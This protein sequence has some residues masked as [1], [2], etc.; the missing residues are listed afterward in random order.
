MSKQCFFPTPSITSN[1]WMSFC[2]AALLQ[3]PSHTNSGN[4]CVNM[5]INFLCSFLLRSSPYPRLFNFAEF[6]SFTLNNPSK[7]NE[8]AER[9]MKVLRM[10]S[11]CR[12][13]IGFYHWQL[14]S[15]SLAF[16]HWW[17]HLVINRRSTFIVS[18]KYISLNY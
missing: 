14:K 1:V 10:F 15:N 4:F 13:S 2:K 7:G 17:L 18:L 16:T 9:H 3:W 6:S 5:K 11:L 12:V 8:R